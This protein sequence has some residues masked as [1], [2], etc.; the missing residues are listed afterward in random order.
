MVRSQ[1]VANKERKHHIQLLYRI[2]PTFVA[3][4]GILLLILVTHQIFHS[5]DLLRRFPQLSF[6]EFYGTILI[7]STTS[8]ITL[9]LFTT[10]TYLGIA[11]LV[12]DQC[13]TAKGD[14]VHRYYR[15]LPPS[16]HLPQQKKTKA[17]FT[18]HPHRGRTGRRRP[19][20]RLHPSS[21]RA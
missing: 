15:P 1:S 3:S 21:K 2:Y 9:I 16:H 8:I 19:R 6:G 11:L 17:H 10:L 12:N 4:I 7:G 18:T 5:Y 20:G 14:L 13:I